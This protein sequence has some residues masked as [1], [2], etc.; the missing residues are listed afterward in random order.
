MPRCGIA[1]TFGGGRNGGS[2]ATA[3]VP[4]DRRA[5]VACSQPAAAVF[6][7]I[8]HHCEDLVVGPER[9]R[10]TAVAAP[11]PI[12]E[13]ALPDWARARSPRAR[14]LEA[15]V[16]GLVRLGRGL[17]RLGLG[18]AQG[19]AVLVQCRRLAEGP[20]AT[21]AA[22][23]YRHGSGPI[24]APGRGRPVVSFRRRV[25]TSQRHGMRDMRCF[26]GGPKK[27]THFGLRIL[28][29]QRRGDEALP[30][31]ER[32]PLLRAESS[33]SCTPRPDG[34]SHNHH[35]IDISETSARGHGLGLS[36]LGSSV[37]C[38]GHDEVAGAW[39]GWQGQTL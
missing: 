34:V 18:L 22:V 26:K 2:A 1:V 6:T 23:R 20:A 9:S 5:S 15:A 8:E 38:C 25:W 11:F 39:G 3:L 36:D 33:T 28:G 29:R 35:I 32:P 27:G 10:S 19:R 37:S 31:M 14:R 4:T 13:R 12:P 21:A 7:A 16:R 17:V 24:L 30:R